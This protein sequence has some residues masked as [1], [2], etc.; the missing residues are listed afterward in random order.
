MTV[1]VFV[2]VTVVGVN[3]DRI[4]PTAEKSSGVWCRSMWVEYPALSCVIAGPALKSVVNF[5]DLRLEH[6]INL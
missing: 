1:A 3:S 2:A 6:S 4:Y 5:G